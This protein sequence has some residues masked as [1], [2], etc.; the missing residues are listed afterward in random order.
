MPYTILLEQQFHF[1]MS[2]LGYLRKSSSALSLN[3]SDLTPEA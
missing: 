1:A 2:Q 3:L